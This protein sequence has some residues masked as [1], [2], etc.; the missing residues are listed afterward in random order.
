MTLWSALA[1]PQ[2]EIYPHKI[3]CAR[4]FCGQIRGGATSHRNGPCPPG[5]LRWDA[6]LQ[7]PTASSADFAAFPG[8]PPWAWNPWI[9]E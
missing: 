6:K 3:F 2:L 7:L 5:P 4:I 8:F 1:Y 9:G